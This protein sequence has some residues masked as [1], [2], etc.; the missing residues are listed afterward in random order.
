MTIERSNIENIMWR[1]KVDNSLFAHKTT[2]I[3]R[4]Y[5]KQWK[6]KKYFPGKKEVVSIKF[7][8]ETFEGYITVTKPKGRANEAHRLWISD[9]LLEE[10]KK[11]YL[12]SHIRY[13]EFLMR[14]QKNV[15]SAKAMTEIENETPFWEFLDI[16]F[17]ESKKEFL[18]VTHYKQVPSF[19]ELFKNMVGSP[20]LK[21]IEDSLFGNSGHKIHK[22]DWKEKSQLNTEL[23]AKNVIY[24][25]LDN[26]NKLIY[27]GETSQNLVTRLNDKEFYKK[28][29]PNWTHYRYDALPPSIDKKGRVAI[30]VLMIRSYAALFESNNEIKSFE[31]SDYK[32][33]NRRFDK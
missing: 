8:K 3:P 23:G 5:A 22:Q 19:P 27:V 33:V 21:Q 4:A 31:I 25:L 16:E 1:K 14:K 13:L 11:V 6:L 30:E 20:K 12:M 10:L 9:G 18:F 24:T 7:Q 28:I 15:K 26:K 29:I 32:L 17:I 2:L